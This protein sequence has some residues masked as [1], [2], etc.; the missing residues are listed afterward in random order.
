MGGTQW[1]QGYVIVIIGDGPH[2]PC[3]SHMTCHTVGGKGG[4]SSTGWVHVEGWLLVETGRR[5]MGARTYWCVAT[6]HTL[7]TCEV[8]DGVMSA[9]AES[10]MLQLS[11]IWENLHSVRDMVSACTDCYDSIH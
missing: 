1:G 8:V 4:L 9:I 7:N 6:S 5:G 3:D 11:L 10:Q 2:Y